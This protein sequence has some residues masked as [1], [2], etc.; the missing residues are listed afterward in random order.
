MKT[1]VILH[2][3]QKTIDNFWKKVQVGGP[4]ECWPWIGAIDKWG[5]GKFA[6]QA[7]DRKVQVLATRFSFTVAKGKIPA[8]KFIL[9][10]CDNPACVNPNH[11]FIG[12]HNEN[13]E[14]MKRKGRANSKL[15]ADDVRRILAI[16]STGLTYAAIARQFGVSESSIQ[17]IFSGRTWSWLNNSSVSQ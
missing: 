14:D 17:G 5:Y 8:G 4:D 16:K 3:S 9:H 7:S 12:T 13:M 10:K 1:N 15:S 11:L 6:Y 2:D